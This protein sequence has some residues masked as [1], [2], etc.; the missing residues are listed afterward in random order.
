M[1]EKRKMSKRIEID[2][3]TL[4]QLVDLLYKKIEEK[5]NLKGKFTLEN[6]KFAKMGDDYVVV[7]PRGVIKHKILNPNK[8]YNIRFE[9]II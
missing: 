8:K 9:E 3:N 4:N 5:F 6:H 1:G 7:I 2:Y